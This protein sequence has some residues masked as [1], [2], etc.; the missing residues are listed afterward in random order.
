ME[1]TYYKILFGFRGAEGE[2]SKVQVYYNILNYSTSVLQNRAKVSRSW[3]GTGQG[4]NV[5]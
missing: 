5:S 4:T 2:Q 3:S 1:Q